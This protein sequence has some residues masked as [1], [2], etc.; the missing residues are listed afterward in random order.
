MKTAIFKND[1]TPS[2]NFT[3]ATLQRRIFK[4]SNLAFICVNKENFLGDKTRKNI[5]QF[6]RVLGFDMNM[7]SANGYWQGK[8]YYHQSL[9]PNQPKGSY[10]AGAILNFIKPELSLES[11]WYAV[12]KGYNAEVGFMPRTGF[13]RSAS[14]I[15]KNVFPR[16]GLSKKINNWSYGFDYDVIYSQFDK[17]ITDWDANLLFGTRFQNLAQFRITPLRREYTYLFDDFDPTNKNEPG[18]LVLKKGTSYYYN[19]TRVSYSSNFR[20][21]FFY[22]IQSRFGQYFNGKIQ[23]VQ[24]DINFRVQPWALLQVSA[25]YNRIRLQQ[26]Y[27][28]ADFLVTGLRSDITFSRSLFWTTFVQ[29]NNQINNVNINSRLQWRFKPMSDLFIVYTNNMFAETVGADQRFEQKNNALVV[30]FNYWFNL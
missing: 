2:A 18:F 12:G 6:N 20:K 9:Q 15:F 21:P 29:Y 19:S 8:T 23:S 25:N 30:K 26:G 13:Y 24:A 27:N 4:R 14:T 3:V 1:S 5:N 7:A 17:R 16:N 11:N 28:K 10:S 22:N